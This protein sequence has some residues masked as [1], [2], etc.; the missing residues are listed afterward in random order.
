M[1]AFLT[2]ALIV[3]ALVGITDA[4]Y[5]TYEKFAGVVPPCQPGYDCAGVLNS[6][7]ASVGPIPVSALGVLYYLSVLVV[8]ISY[9]LEF[10]LIG[11]IKSAFPKKISKQLQSNPVWKNFDADH[12]LMALTSFGFAFSIFLVGLMAFVIQAWC[13][14]CLIS[15]ASSSLLFLLGS[16]LYWSNNTL[17]KRA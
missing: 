10:D 1:K 13:F 14:Y 3:V 8:S 2:L 7:W 15:A 6:K 11:K 16:A 17:N 5:I 9:Y 4:S 12:T